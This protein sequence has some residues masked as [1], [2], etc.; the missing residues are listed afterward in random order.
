MA[1][2]DRNSSAKSRSETASR[3]LSVGRSK[4]SARGGHGRS[5][6]NEV[7]ARA[8]LPSGQSFSRRRQSR[9][10]A[11]VAVQHLHVGQQV[12][13]EGDG[14]RGLQV[15]EAGHRV[16]RVLGGAVRPGPAWR[17]P[18]SRSG[19]R[20]RRAPTGGNRWPPGR[21]GCARCAAACRPRRRV[22]SAGPR[23]SCGCLPDATSKA[24][25][26]AS[27]SA[28]SPLDRCDGGLIFVLS[29]PICASMAACAR[30]AA[31]SCRHSLRSKPMEALMSCMI[32]D[33]PPAKRPPHCALADAF[34]GRSAG[35]GSGVSVTKK[36]PTS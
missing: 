29:S 22:R 24:K 21:C 3:E 17:R 20:S 35:R 14:L 28:R 7:P 32:T 8:A 1:A 16:G 13:A 33:G 9:Q 12:V 6:G 5:I 2:A 4:P 31:I 30:D 10:A 34:G 19:R 25:W 11:A 36:V 18:V 23:C 15:G 27:I 26:P